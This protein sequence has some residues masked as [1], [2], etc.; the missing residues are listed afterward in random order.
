MQQQNITLSKQSDLFTFFEKVSKES[1]L[2]LLSDFDIE[3]DNR[4]DFIA[5]S[6]YSN[7]YFPSGADGNIRYYL[8]T[9]LR[10]I[11]YM[12]PSDYLNL[13]N[14]HISDCVGFYD[15]FAGL[16]QD[17]PELSGTVGLVSPNLNTNETCDYNLR[18]ILYTYPFFN[19][20]NGTD[21][22]KAIQE[23][24]DELFKLKIEI[25]D[26]FNSK[27]MSE[28]SNTIVK[29]QDFNINDFNYTTNSF[30]ERFYYMKEPLKIYI[31]G[32]DILTAN[33]YIYV[34]LLAEFFDTY[35]ITT[36]KI[37]RNQ[38]GLVLDE[39]IF[40]FIQGDIFPE[41]TNIES[42]DIVSGDIEVTTR[43]VGTDYEWATLYYNYLN[44]GE[45]SG[46]D[47]IENQ[48]QF[49]IQNNYA[50]FTFNW[51]TTQLTDDSVYKLRVVF[52]DTKGFQ[53]NATIVNITVINSPPNITCSAFFLNDQGWQEIQDLEHVS[54]TIK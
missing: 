31:Y 41:F 36:E 21:I 48:T 30:G 33:N 8:P 5:F 2:D 16:L 27:L 46:W 45:Y 15:T 13:V 51:S 12:T 53:G 4:D 7:S 24:K 1:Y 37:F 52:Q 49:T 34:K 42:F 6:S 54:G 10:S 11:E 20:Q 44:L 32:Q 39:L 35:Y 19:Y 50:Y 23:F 40:E 9:N 38:W 29:M 22:D 18:T 14:L 26:Q 17:G 28:Y 3:I 47:L 43:A 25:Y